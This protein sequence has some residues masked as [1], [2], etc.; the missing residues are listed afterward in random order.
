MPIHWGLILFKDTSWVIKSPG[1]QGDPGEQSENIPS[2][3]SLGLHK[4]PDYL[5]TRQSEAAHIHR[6]DPPIRVKTELCWNFFGL[7][8]ASEST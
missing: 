6:V 4:R 8:T 1:P 7:K 2:R 3:A 5:V